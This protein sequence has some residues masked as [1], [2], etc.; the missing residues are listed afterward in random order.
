MGEGPGPLRTLESRL[1]RAPATARHASQCLTPELRHAAAVETAPNV[2][3]C[4]GQAYATAALFP[5]G[6]LLPLKDAVRKPQGSPLGDSV[7]VE[8]LLILLEP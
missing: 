5:K 7:T 4:R 8:L 6:Y 1:A 2:R 3:I